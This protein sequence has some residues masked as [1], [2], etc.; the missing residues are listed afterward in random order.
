MSLA[1]GARIGS[2][3]ILSRLGEGGMGVVFRA[4]DTQLLRDVA[5][6]LL[7]DHFAADAGRLA[8]FQREA[9]L[10]ASFN[11]PNIAQIYGFEQA[12][13]S[14]A[15][16][17]ELVEGETLADRLKR[18]PFPVDAAIPIAKQIVDALE[19]AHARTI[20]HR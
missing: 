17:M 16:V 13:S 20:I 7:P 15:I 4:R 9:Q 3:E 2:Y 5:V 18:G 19:A 14:G 8:R 6:K 12:G 11:H 1:P 10:L